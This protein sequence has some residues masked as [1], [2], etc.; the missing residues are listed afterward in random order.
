MI[1]GFLL[2][3]VVVT[4]L[5]YDTRNAAIATGIPEELAE[6]TSLVGTL[7]RLEAAGLSLVEMVLADRDSWD[8]YMAAQWWTVDEWL[9]EHP[10]DPDAPAMRRYL[11]HARRSHLEYQREFLGWGVFVCRDAPDRSG[12]SGDTT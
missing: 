2:A 8:R 3:V 5:G 12:V 6:F 11:D 9:R 7:D 1:P 10:A 4:A